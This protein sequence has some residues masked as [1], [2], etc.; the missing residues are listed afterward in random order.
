LTLTSGLG[1]TY[2]K[3]TSLPT[4][5]EFVASE[6]INTNSQFVNT[7]KVSFSLGAEYTTHVTQAIDATGRIDYSHK[8]TINYDPTNSPLL[9]QSPYGLLDARLTFEYVPSKI[10]LAI[11]GTNLTNKHYIVGGYDDADTPTTGLGVAFQDM[12]PP[13]EWG[14]TAEI[15]F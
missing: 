13:R 10:S 4:D 15:R 12:A 1:L 5:A 9:R 11:F 2:A 7:P 6:L 3:Y 8:T 14:V